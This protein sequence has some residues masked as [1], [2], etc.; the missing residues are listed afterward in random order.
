MDQTCLP[1]WVK[2]RKINTGWIWRHYKKTTYVMT[3][4][5]W[6]YFCVNW[7]RVTH[8]IA[9]R[10]GAPRIT[11]QNTLL[12]SYTTVKTS[13]LIIYPLQYEHTNTVPVHQKSTKD[14]N[15][16]RCIRGGGI[17]C[18]HTVYIYNNFY[19]P[20][21][22]WAGPHCPH[23]QVSHIDPFPRCRHLDDRWW[24][25]NGLLHMQYL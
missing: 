23:V 14:L 4:V 11:S 19:Q 9:S 15:T 24:L 21:L 18:I 7:S 1:R 8:T 20:V 5:F 16:Q 12:F 13:N 22:V 25:L 17:Y 10:I 2:P 3:E 6:D